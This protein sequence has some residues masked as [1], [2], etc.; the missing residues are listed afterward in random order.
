[1]CVLSHLYL[2][3]FVLLK[4]DGGLFDLNVSI[5]DSMVIGLSF[6]SSTMTALD[7]HFN[8]VCGNIP[9]FIIQMSII[10]T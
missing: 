10:E 7:W 4:E 3:L 9:C 5:T 1:V 8:R 6:I 2:V